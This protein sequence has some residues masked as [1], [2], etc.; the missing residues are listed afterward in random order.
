[1]RGEGGYIMSE[2]SAQVHLCMQKTRQYG[3][4]V[5]GLLRCLCVLF[6]QSILIYILCHFKEMHKYLYMFR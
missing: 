3:V 5:C 6:K 2:G 1:M 4:C